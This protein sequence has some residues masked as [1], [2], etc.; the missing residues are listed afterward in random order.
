NTAATATYRTPAAR[1]P[2]PRRSTAPGSLRR[3]APGRAGTSFWEGVLGEVG[4][5]AAADLAAEPHHFLLLGRGHTVLDAIVDVG[6]AHPAPH[7]LRRHIKI[8]GDLV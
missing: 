6:L 8:G 7:R 1:T 3:P 4:G 2:A 5:R